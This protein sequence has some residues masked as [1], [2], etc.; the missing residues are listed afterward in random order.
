LTGFPNENC[1]TRQRKLLVPSLWRRNRN[2][3]DGGT[4]RPDAKSPFVAHTAQA[5]ART[6]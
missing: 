4:F 2:G 5:L 3:P 1:A 6:P